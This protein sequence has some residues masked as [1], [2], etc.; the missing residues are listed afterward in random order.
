MKP[1]VE[2][3]EGIGLGVIIEWPSGVQ[4]LQRPTTSVAAVPPCWLLNVRSLGGPR[5]TRLD[6]L[7]LRARALVS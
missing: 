7:R 2:L 4:E 1:K 3:W 5:W 6:R